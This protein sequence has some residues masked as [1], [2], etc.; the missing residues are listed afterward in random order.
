MKMQ[1]TLAPVKASISRPAL[2]NGLTV[3]VTVTDL[4]CSFKAKLILT[5][6]IR[7]GR[8]YWKYY[9]HRICSLLS[10]AFHR[11]ELITLNTGAMPDNLKGLVTNNIPIA[12]VV[13]TVTSL[14]LHVYHTL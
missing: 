1:A 3:T 10:S 8:E 6:S 7:I 4:S 2:T 11:S 9:S 5:A 12:F 14:P 13:L